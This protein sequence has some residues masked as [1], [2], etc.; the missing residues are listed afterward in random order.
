[1][2]IGMDLEQVARLAAEVTGIRYVKEETQPSGQRITRLGE[3]T[4]GSLDAVFGGAGAR[5]LIDELARGSQGNDAG[6]R[7]LR[8]TRRD[9]ATT[10]VPVTSTVRATCSSVR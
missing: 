2:G 9:A 6:L 8:G 4:G 10:S 1:M 3:L 7:D 5:Y